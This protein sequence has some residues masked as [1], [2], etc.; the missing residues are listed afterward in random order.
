MPEIIQKPLQ[1]AIT[2]HYVEIGEKVKEIS[3]K[4]GIDDLVVTGAI[5]LS[6]V[7]NM[8]ILSVHLICCGVAE[9]KSFYFF[10]NTQAM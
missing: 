9:Q 8:K 3:K 2:S 10:N 7:T 4:C 1:T 5:R 6:L